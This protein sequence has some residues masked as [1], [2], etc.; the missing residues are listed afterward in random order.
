MIARVLVAC[1][2]F[3]TIAHAEG[4]TAA[5]TPAADDPKVSISIEPVFLMAGIVEANVEVEVAPHLGIQAIAG[6]GGILGGRIAELGAEANIYVRPELRGL[7]VGTELKY[8]WGSGTVIP[9]VDMPET[10]VTER[11]LAVYAGWKWVGWRHLTTVV[12]VGVSR[13]DLSGDI[14]MDTPRSQVVPAA[15]LTLGYSF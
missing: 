11:E 9:F 8:L 5:A 14:A 4:I 7:H 13:L 15:N 1:S 12:Q 2:L 3:T 6:Y 10:H